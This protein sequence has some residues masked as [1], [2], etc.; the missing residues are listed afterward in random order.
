M[1]HC[2]SVNVLWLC[3][4]PALVFSQQAIE[5]PLPAKLTAEQLDGP[6]IVTAKAWAIADGKSGKVLWGHKETEALTMASTTKIMTVWIVIRLAK[7]EPKVLDEI[8]V[9][10][11]KAAKTGGSSAKIQAGD[12]Y[13]V[14]DLLYGLLLPSGND[15]ATALAEHFG[16]RNRGDGKSSEDPITLFVAEMNREA[17]TLKM[18]NTKYYDPHGLGKNHSSVKDL[19]LLAAHALKEPSF[20]KYVQT[21]RYHCEVSN[22]KGEKRMAIW[23]NTNQ[24]LGIEGYDGVKT[25]TTTAAGSCLVASGRRETSH[26]IVVVLGCT[27]NE[28]RYADS[29]NLFR[30]AWREQ[31]RNKK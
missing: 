9:V 18:E 29:R 13:V 6:P 17:S 26:L 30:W 11:E 4:L 15:A 14:R 2:L 28:S 5:S 22:E 10:S 27:S 1:S 31:E 24:L 16:Q 8:L 3:L 7:Q 23:N 12:H 21:R 25:G 19:A 20:A